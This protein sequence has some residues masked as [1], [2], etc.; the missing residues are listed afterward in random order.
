MSATFT[1]SEL[2]MVQ[3]LLE[4]MYPGHEFRWYVHSGGA[5]GICPNPE[6]N[7]T[8]PSFSLY[9]RR[10]KWR[11]YCFGCGMKGVVDETFTTSAS[12]RQFCERLLEQR[13]SASS[14]SKIHDLSWTVGYCDSET[15]F[16]YLE[17]R[18]IKRDAME[19]WDVRAG[20]LDGEWHVVVPDKL[21]GEFTNFYQRRS[22]VRK[23]YWTSPGS[24]PIMKLWKFDKQLLFLVEGVFDAMAMYPYALPLLGKSLTMLQFRQLLR[25]VEDS[26]IKC[27]VVL[28]DGGEEEIAR[29]LAERLVMSLMPSVG[30]GYG[31]LP[32][33]EDPNSMVQKYGL[34]EFVMGMDVY[35][36]IGDFDKV[37]GRFFCG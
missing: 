1:K 36:L 15:V 31:R 23:E 14:L 16:G 24:K 4:S 13:E 19:W 33:G 20:V 6:H 28:L 34:T 11:Y 29:R 27:I 8:K 10:G 37:I 35:S 32:R 5:L 26:N 7:D 21:M 3:K 9:K 2:E 12:L 22:V 25:K 18:G 17:S 30:V